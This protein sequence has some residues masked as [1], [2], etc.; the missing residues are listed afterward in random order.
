[1]PETSEDEALPALVSELK[2][3]VL[4]YLQQET[5]EPIKD[6]GRF[7]LFG[8]VG[9]AVLITGLTLLLVGLLRGLQEETG[10]TFTGNLTWV[11]YG[12]CA[13]TGLAVTGLAA[14]AITRGRGKSRA[15]RG[16]GA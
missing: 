12:I 11:P 1:M 13:L 4:R 6:L 9:S 5:L 3:L 15:K 7:V 14:A 16:A 10:S 2:D 8:I